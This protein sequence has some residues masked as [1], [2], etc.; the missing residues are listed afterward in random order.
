M[1]N[2]VKLNCYGHTQDNFP[3]AGKIWAF[4]R[5]GGDKQKAPE[6]LSKDT[7]N[8]KNDQKNQTF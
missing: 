5:G 7:Q 1:N 8:T 3:G 6:T 4:Q 2:T